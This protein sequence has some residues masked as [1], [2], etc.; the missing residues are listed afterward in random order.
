MRPITLTRTNPCLKIR[1]YPNTNQADTQTDLE[2]TSYI[3]V[4]AHLIMRN[5][6]LY[7]QFYPFFTKNCNLRAGRATHHI[8]PERKKGRGR[9]LN[10]G[11]SRSIPSLSPPNTTKKKVD[12]AARRH[13]VI[14][15]GE[16]SA[17]SRAESAFD[18]APLIRE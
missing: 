18:S 15:G 16:E 2:T 13:S 5:Q 4:H 17:R 14:E 9:T 8:Y 1:S 6:L 7:L 11:R 12:A 3:A 10:I